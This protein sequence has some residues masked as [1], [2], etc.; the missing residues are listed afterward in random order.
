MRPRR[1]RLRAA[2]LL[3]VLVIFLATALHSTV[4]YTR[5]WPIF[6]KNTKTSPSFFR[7]IALCAKKKRKPNP[8]AARGFGAKKRA[9]VPCP[10][11]IGSP[12]DE[13][14]C[15]KLHATLVKGSKAQAGGGGEPHLGSEF[16]SFKPSDIVRSR[17][18]AYAVKNVPFIIKSTST[19]N[20]QHYLE[21]YELWKGRLEDDC[22]ESFSLKKCEILSTTY[23]PS[24]EL[25]EG[26]ECKVEFKAYMR[27]KQSGE[28]MSF[29]ELSTFRWEEI[30][31]GKDEKGLGWLYSFG[32]VE[33]C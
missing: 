32:D 27:D 10:C 2:V 4:S 28:E 29:I 13:C 18:S 22:Y 1:S 17:F 5:A 30:G 12:Y 24:I 31:D 11:G 33:Q 26:D 6:L 20:P 16:S 8:A 19:K 7:N 3:E 23:D 9:S 15:S 21:D 14:N 25:R